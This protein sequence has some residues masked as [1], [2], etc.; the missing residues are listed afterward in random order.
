MDPQKA[1][2]LPKR[3][4]MV[5]AASADAS[6]IVA[7]V[8]L[9]KVANAGRKVPGQREQPMMGTAESF[10]FVLRSSLLH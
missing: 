3:K 9:S 4:V 10:K 6:W 5:A 8:D 7:A 1:A 2:P